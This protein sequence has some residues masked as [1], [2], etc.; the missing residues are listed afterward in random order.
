MP[1]L[2]PT[3]DVTKP[4]HLFIP[5]LTADGVGAL[6]IVHTG[7]IALDAGSDGGTSRN[8]TVASFVPYGDSGPGNPPTAGMVQDFSNVRAAGVVTASLGGLRVS[9]NDGATAFIDASVLR[10]GTQPN[11][12]GAGGA[13]LCLMIGIRV[14]VRL[15]NISRIAY[16]VTVRIESDP[17]NEHSIDTVR[18]IPNLIPA[19][20][21]GGSMVNTGHSDPVWPGF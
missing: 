7:T 17:E 4:Q 10:L 12:M 20:S 16:Q 3:K 11:L 14:G 5:Y 8:E 1:I 18:N 19:G 13:P 2:V 9:P 6:Q 15:A 21:P